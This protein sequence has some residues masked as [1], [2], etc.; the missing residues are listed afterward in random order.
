M[1]RAD[2]V[3]GSGEAAFAWDRLVG[4]A[5][6]PA[7]IPR[8]YSCS[9]GHLVAVPQPESSDSAGGQPQRPVSAAG[10]PEQ[11]G[12]RRGSASAMHASRSAS[13]GANS[14]LEAAV[15]GA[16]RDADAAGPGRGDAQDGAGPAARPAPPEAFVQV[17]LFSTLVNLL[18]FLFD[19]RRLGATPST[20]SSDCAHLEAASA[21]PGLTLVHCVHLLRCCRWRP[22][23]WWAC[24]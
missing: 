10:Q 3:G 7:P 2:L 18:G 21:H 24:T 4:E 9:D 12:Q 11:L 17:L 15:D 23:R 20:S 14:H 13:A 6:N 1:P 19:S 8:S 22:S 16:V 5:L